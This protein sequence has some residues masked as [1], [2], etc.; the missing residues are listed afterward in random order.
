VLAAAGRGAGWFLAAAAAVLAP[1]RAIF[2]GQLERIVNPAHE[3]AAGFWI[4]TLF[5]MVV[6]G[7]RR[8][9]A[10]RSRRSGAECWWR[11]W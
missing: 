8:H 3:L 5:L 6:A 10:A 7:S 9:C 1:L 4:G 11:A 2:F